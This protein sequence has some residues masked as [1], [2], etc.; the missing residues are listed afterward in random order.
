MDG[1]IVV[2]K[3]SGPT[4][5]EIVRRIKSRLGRR[6]RV[7]HLGTLDPFATGVLP[8]LVGEG[9]K[10]A[11][12]L[13]EGHKEYQCII[14]IGVESDTIDR[15]GAVVRT[16]AVPALGEARL[17]EVAAQF[18]GELEQTPP[19][20]S[21]IKRDGVRLYRL[22]RRGGEVAP[23]PPR[24]VKIMRLTL[25]PIDGA[26]LGFSVM[27][28]P[29]MY[30]RSL[31]RDIGVALGSVAHLAELCRVRSGTF[32]IDQTRPFDQVMAALEAGSDP[33]LIGLRQAIKDAPEVE[34]DAAIEQ[35]L[36]HG[37]S[38]VLDGLAPAGAILFK[39]VA[40][41]E[42]AAIAKAT[43][44]VTATIARVFGPF[45]AVEPFAPGPKLS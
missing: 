37:D 25:R 5:A 38:R 36:R 19:I 24:K 27:C 4:S 30:V 16:A 17:A 8:V 41:G 40:R 44:R 1:V 39:V 28:S 10:L 22:A 7:G 15:T 20:F 43:S 33:G 6:A 45:D 42:L 14:A 26:A 12:F 18:T 29:G 35:R 21:A 13:Q 31:A 32:T 34:V 9:T 23:P 2:D 3:P 11:P